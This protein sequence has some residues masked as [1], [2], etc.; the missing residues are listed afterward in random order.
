M[1]EDL[2][3]AEVREARRQILG[4][5]GGDLDALFREP[6]DHERASGRKVLRGRPR[7]PKQR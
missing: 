2:I 6:K 5:H 1:R 7:T 3:V 4:K